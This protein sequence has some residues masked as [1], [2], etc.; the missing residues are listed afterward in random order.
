[1]DKRGNISSRNMRSFA[2]IMTL[3]EALILTSLAGCADKK[4]DYGTDTALFVSF[5]VSVP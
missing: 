1:M 4:V 5:S 2:A 3:I